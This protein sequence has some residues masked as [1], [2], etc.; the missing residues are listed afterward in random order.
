MDNKWAAIENKELRRIM[1]SEAAHSILQ[2]LNSGSC[3]IIEGNQARPMKAWLFHRDSN[4]RTEL[5]KVMQGMQWL[6]WNT[7]FMCSGR[8]VAARNETL[9]STALTDAQDAVERALEART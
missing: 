3:R 5:E 8:A 9:G 1:L 6:P 7:K 4:L 2:A